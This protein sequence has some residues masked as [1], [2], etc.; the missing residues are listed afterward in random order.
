MSNN[1]PEKWVIFGSGSFA[2]NRVAPALKRSGFRGVVIRCGSMAQ[3]DDAKHGIT[4]STKLDVDLLSNSAVWLCSDP[5]NNAKLI[6]VMLTRRPSHII[7]EKPLFIESSVYVALKT[8]DVPIY[9]DFAFEFHP[10]WIFIKQQF[11]KLECGVI[12]INFILPGAPLG[13]RKEYGA[14]EDLGVYCI[15]ALL[16]LL[17]IT[18]WSNCGIYLHKVSKNFTITT[19]VIIYKSYKF[20][21]SWGYGCAYDASIKILA[22]DKK[23]VAERIFSKD[24]E[25]TVSVN[26]KN[27]AG[28]K[29]SIFTFKFDQLRYLATAILQSGFKHSEAVRCSLERSMLAQEILDADHFYIN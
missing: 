14:D 21:L 20:V 18:S 1:P 2:L 11:R 29:E 7:V 3:E 12:H 5:R 16:S 6:E 28:N 17:G 9:V 13:Y 4:Y 10:Q 15:F 23:V 19:G 26:M 24:P 27:Q 8:Q 22:K 25:E